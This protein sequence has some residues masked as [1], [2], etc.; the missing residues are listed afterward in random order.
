MPT[1]RTA[2][3]LL[4]PDGPVTL[5]ALDVRRRGW[6]PVPIIPGTKRPPD[7]WT[8]PEYAADEA[9]VRSEF[10]RMVDGSGVG[11]RL[12]RGL[13]DVD[14]DSDEARR[15]APLLL[16]STPARSGRDGAEAGHW[17]YLLSDAEDVP[18]TTHADA[19]GSMLVEVR[20]DGRHQTVVPPSVHP[21]GMTYVWSGQSW[22][23]DDGPA[24]ATASEV[25]AGAASVALVAVLAPVWPG[26][27]SRNAAFLALAG[28]LLRAAHEHPG[29]VAATGDV[30]KALAKMTGDEEGAVRVRETVKQTVKKLSEGGETTGWPTLAGLLTTDRP[31]AVVSA[32]KR[33][34]EA[35]RDALGVERVAVDVVDRPAEGSITD[36]GRGRRVILTPASAIPH[37]RVRWLW[38]GRL[39][40]GTLSLL[41]GREGL[42]KSS[43]AYWL[44]AQVTRGT[45]PGEFAGDERAVLVC[46]TED[47]WGHTI[48][49]RLE[50]AGAD[51]ARV[52]RLEVTTSEGLDGSLSLPLDLDAV[53]AAAGE[54]GA[55]LLLLDPLT[56][57]LAAA[58]DT[59]K[60]A[61]VRRALEPLARLAERADAA[62]L[63]LMHHNKSGGTDP[64]RAVMASVAFTAVARSV[65]TVVPDPEDESVRLFGTV[66]NNLGRG[67]LPSLSF[68]VETAL[69]PTDDG[70]AP[71]GRVVIGDEVGA[72]IAD[73][74]RRSA[75]IE[76]GGR[77]EPS[78]AAVWL[79]GYLRA[80]GQSV[81]GL[82]DE[83]RWVLSS[84]VKAAAAEA[85]HSDKQVRNARNRLGVESRAE[86]GYFPQ[87]TWWGLVSR[88]PEELE[89]H[90][91]ADSRAL[92]AVVPSPGEGA[93]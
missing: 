8:S 23:G 50:A 69:V 49:P 55:A 73:V 57:R 22:G 87:R 76:G 54:V 10:G 36:S 88:A 16:P 14:L 51:L 62:V 13:V 59:H 58:L 29:M 28:G 65:H 74:M 71:V 41:A 68:T 85:G 42:G 70:P 40:L 86:P 11:V 32:A 25:L 75:V 63:G 5:A 84:L 83:R 72:S 89:G 38:D 48:G 93:A 46:A 15:A 91:S 67:D 39:A 81:D 3:A 77:G 12:G 17:W 53:E 26:G 9:A 1:L 31:D 19:D 4:A 56:S 2:R 6:T 79:V 33:G 80:N 20:G 44:A 90:D 34:A 21:E 64:V 52:F 47:S 43:F 82:P 35:L 30:V 45:L 61:D 37:R 78:D 7:G 27:G 92:P 24:R 18:W 66:K 60:D